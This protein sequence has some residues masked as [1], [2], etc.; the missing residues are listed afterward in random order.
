MPESASLPVNVKLS[1]WFHQPFTSGERLG[2]APM[3]TGGV[4]SIRRVTEPLKE[5]PPS[6]TVHENVVCPSVLKSR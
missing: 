5:L 2:A 6:D 1:G 4:R 3:I